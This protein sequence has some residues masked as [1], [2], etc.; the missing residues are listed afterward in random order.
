M[1]LRLLL[2]VSLLVT[3]C[4]HKAG[5]P[6]PES[7]DQPDVVKP[8]DPT[9]LSVEVLKVL[10][11][12]IDAGRLVDSDMLLGQV[13][14]LQIRGGLD[15]ESVKRFNT[16]FP[17]LAKKARKLTAADAAKLRAL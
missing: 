4:A 11:D 6:E 5:G 1:L 10:A 16:S 9:A 12:D 13:G 15:A 2:I 17:D 7:D 3:G 14:Q 8:V